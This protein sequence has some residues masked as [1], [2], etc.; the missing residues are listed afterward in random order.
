[1][2]IFYIKEKLIILK[3]KFKLVRFSGYFCISYKKNWIFFNLKC[4][5]FN[6]FSIK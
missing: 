3:I 1:M 4:L 6:K 5:K 2:K